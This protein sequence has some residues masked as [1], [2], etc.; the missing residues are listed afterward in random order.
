ML[1]GCEHPPLEVY[2]ELSDEV[3][4]VRKRL[5]TNSDKFECGQPGWVAQAAV[6]DRIKA[7][8][9]DKRARPIQVLEQCQYER[10]AC[11][12]DYQVLLP[13]QLQLLEIGLVLHELVQIAQVVLRVF[14][15]LYVLGS[16]NIEQLDE[17]AGQ[18]ALSVSEKILVAAYSVDCCGCKP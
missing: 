15:E 18:P 11:N 14:L 4:P 2:H 9:A 8:L 1:R 10:L 5:E 13:F 17:K 3:G 6:Y 12:V 16:R 7:P